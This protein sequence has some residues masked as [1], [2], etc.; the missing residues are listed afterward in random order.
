[1]PRLTNTTILLTHTSCFHWRF[2]G[3]WQ[4][5]FC[6][7][8][9]RWFGPPGHLSLGSDRLNVTVRR[10]CTV[11][12]WDVQRT[13][14]S[15][16]IQVFLELLTQVPQTKWNIHQYKCKTTKVLADF[17]ECFPFANRIFTM[18]VAKILQVLWN[19]KLIWYNWRLQSIQTFDCFP[20]YHLIHPYHRKCPVKPDW[21]GLWVT[22]IHLTT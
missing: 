14:G 21:V 7:R 22:G 3:N 2:S 19:T 20:H 6:E 9:I 16:S 10:T 13:F 18:F 4:E 15:W 17:L 11:P 1:M 12:L 8:N 5:H